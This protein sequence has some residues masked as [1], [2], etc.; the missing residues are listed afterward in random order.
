M[1]VQHQNT[2]FLWTPK[3]HYSRPG[4]LYWKRTIFT[5]IKCSYVFIEL[6]YCCKD[7]ISV[8]LKGLSIYLRLLLDV[9]YS[10]FVLASNAVWCFIIA[11]WSKLLIS[12]LLRL[13]KYGYKPASGYF[14]VA[15]NMVQ[16]KWAC[17]VVEVFKKSIMS[18]I[19]SVIFK[20]YIC[21]KFIIK[22]LHT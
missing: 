6:L 18:D 8:C 15:L 20:G 11:N 19:L 21:L 5:A 9:N 17:T 4:S 3:M 1:K 22:C 7:L 16:R 10:V 12:P 14:G 13:L 2:G